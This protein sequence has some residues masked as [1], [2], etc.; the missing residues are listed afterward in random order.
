[1]ASL[2]DQINREAIDGD[3]S[4]ALR[5]CLQLGG[6]TGSEALR[7]WASQELTG[8]K[9][10]EELP[11]YRT[12]YAPLQINVFKPGM[13]IQGQTISAISLPDFA[14]DAV[15]EQV[16][17]THS[18]PT[19]VELEKDARKEGAVHLSP[20]GATDLV[21]LW[22]HE[23]NT[24]YEQIERLYW[25]VTRS[26]LQGVLEDIKSR[27]VA[28]VAEMKAGLEPGQA[29]PSAE[30][31]SQAVEVAIHGDKARVKVK[32]SGHRTTITHGD[33]KGRARKALEVAAWVA[34]IAILVVTV[35]VYWDDI[36]GWF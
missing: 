12:V 14:R 2:L 27:L 9:G 15:T 17:L 11:D 24:P 22:N 3:L 31:A 21:A 25:S 1:M 10:Q 36:T 4:R 19:L 29:L 8:Y 33:Q 20:P 13:H 6:E 18:A 16:P 34:G 30:V 7:D 5:L 26:V 28:L 32:Q 23:R 35:I